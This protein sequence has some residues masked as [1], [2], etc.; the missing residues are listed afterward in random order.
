MAIKMIVTDL[1][2]TLLNTQN[3]ISEKNKA[4]FKKAKEKGIIPVVATGRIDKEGWF[5]AEAIGGTDYMLSGNGGVVRDY[6]KD[7]VIFEDALS[8][9]I[10]RQVIELVDQYDGI[11]VQA[12]TIHGCVCTEK[13]FPEMPT[14]GWADE[15]VRQFKEQQIVV[16]DIE[17]YLDKNHLEV[18]K[19]VIS[20]TDFDKLDE[21]Q[22]RAG[23]IVDLVPL[24]PMNYCLECIPEGVDKG[25]GLTKLCEYL[26]ISLTEVM[27]IG[28]SDNDLEMI[29]IAGTKIAMGNAYDCIKT[30][31]DHIVSTNDEDGVAEAIER[32]AL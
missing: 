22:K 12:H 11:F 3:T 21:V 5:A 29:E 20:S 28:D 31:A 6:K 25:L 26:G 1:D 15:Y 8:K 30:I 27:V 19:F 32:F 16:E 4:A 18:S 24:R 14:A 2:G 13:T 7:T 9:E 23:E 10:I 17:G